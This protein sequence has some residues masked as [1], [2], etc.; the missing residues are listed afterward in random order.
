MNLLESFQHHIL[1]AACWWAAA[2]AAFFVLTKLWPCNPGRSWWKAPRSALTDLLYGVFLVPVVGLAGRLTILWVGVMLFFGQNATPEFAARH[3]PLWLQ[4]VLVLLIQDALMYWIHRLFH[5]RHGWEFHAVHH[6]P[7]TL[8]WT[9]STR[10]H[11]VNEVAQYALVDAAALLMGFSPVV[12]ATLGPFQAIYSAMVHANLNW[13]F[14]PLRFVLASPVF[15]RWH[16]SCQ[17]EALGKNFAPTFPFLDLIW[18]TF[19]M[20]S[21]VVP[22]EYGA[23]EPAMPG[24][25]LGQTLFPF[26]G[27]GRWAMRRPALAAACTTMCLVLGYSFWQYVNRPTAQEV[28]SLPQPDAASEPPGLLPS[29]MVRESRQTN[30][31]AVDATGFRVIYGLRDGSV[32]V[33]DIAAGR[34]SSPGQHRSRVNTVATSPGGTWI[35]SASSDGTA[36]VFAAAGGPGRELPHGRANVTCAAASDDGWVATGASDGTIRLWNPNGTLARQQKLEATAV[37]AVAVCEGGTHVA[38]G[39]G[40]QVCSWDVA[41]DHLTKHR[42]LGDLAY[43]LAISRDGRRV[44]AGEYGGRLHLWDADQEQPRLAAK[45]HTGPIYSLAIS[46]DGKSVVTG[47]A[48]HTVRVWDVMSGTVTKELHGHRGMIFSVSCDVG[49]RRV[50]AGGKDGTLTCWDVTSGAVVPASASQLVR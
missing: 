11:P 49:H 10:F 40:S 21:G 7:E 17:S 41:T 23:N 31:V 18:G 44:A 43:C 37:N 45:G 38:A 5:T 25:L 9:S 20:P 16:H 8:D 15:H 50:L 27:A 39:Q 14:G 12:L 22:E 42:R 24:G 6:S 48:D 29:S 46:P 3:W 34:E 26:R 28:A 33:R 13:T 36:L 1:T 47:G 2:A 35:V 4:C 30:S 32:A 19:Y